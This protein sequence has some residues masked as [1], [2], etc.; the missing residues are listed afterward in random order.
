MLTKEL[1]ELAR[2]LAS[3]APDFDDI[4][5]FTACI[6]DYHA[7][8]PELARLLLWEGLSDAPAVHEVERTAHY[9]Q[10]VDRLIVAQENSWITTEIDPAKLLFLL[11]AQAAWWFAV[12][13]LAR[14]VTGVDGRYLI[15]QTAQR[16]CVANAARKLA[17]PR[18]G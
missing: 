11:I 9:R 18:N 8:H 4:G 3:H 16:L 15:E 10:I 7:D 13:Q 17:T 12:P 2:S 14:M 5:E 6:F 1:E